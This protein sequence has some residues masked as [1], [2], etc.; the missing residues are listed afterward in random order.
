[1]NAQGQRVVGSSLIGE[2]KGWGQRDFKDKFQEATYDGVI[3]P[4]N[5]QTH[6][7]VAY[8]SAGINNMGIVAEG[9]SLLDDNYP[10]KRLGGQSFQMGAN[11]SYKP[12][13]LRTIGDDIRRL[14]CKPLPVYI[15]PVP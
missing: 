10:D 3:R 4:D 2:Q 8:M 1:M 12:D 7:A 6:H 15:E 14:L 13:K 5:D 11:L 9:H